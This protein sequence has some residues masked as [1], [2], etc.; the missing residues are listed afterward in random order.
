M[1]DTSS[2]DDEEEVPVSNASEYNW[3]IYADF[4]PATRSGSKILDALTVSVFGHVNFINVQSARIM[5]RAT[6][7]LPVNELP[8][9]ENVSVMLGDLVDSASELN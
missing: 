9:S 1:P 4:V 6:V 5:Q 3:E 8:L 2:D 7:V